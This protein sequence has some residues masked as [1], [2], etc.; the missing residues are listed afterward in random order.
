MKS[1]NQLMPLS[2][3]ILTAMSHQ[4]SAEKYDFALHGYIRSGILANSDGNRVDSVG[5]MP[6]GKWR[7]GNED[8]TKIEL[9]PQVTLTSDSG[10]VAKIQANITH[11]SKCTSDWNCLDED[12][13]AVQFREGYVEMTNLDFAPEVAFWGGKRYS[14]SN[15][16][17]HQFDWEYI[18]YNGTGGGFDNL[19]L[20]FARFDAGI[21]A[22]TPTDESKAFPVD[23]SDQGYPD[24]YSLN[25]WLKK[26]GGSPIDLEVVGHHMN[27][28]EKHVDAA[29]KGYGFTGIYNFDG[30]YGIAGGYS[31]F[32]VQYG[33][34]LAAGDSLGKNGWG[35]AN[36]EDTQSWRVVLDGM[37]SLGEWDISTFAYYQKDKNYRW[38]SSDEKGWGRTSWVAGVR[39]YQQI[40]KHFA[41]Q[42]EVGYEYLDDDNYKGVDG[43]GKGGLTKVTIAPTLTFDSGFWSRPQLR[44]FATYAK[45]D[46]GVS[47]ALDGNYNWDTNSI[48]AGGYS[49]SGKTD[50]LNF[51]IQAEVWF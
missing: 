6:D 45:W 34:G 3:L 32:V 35:W 16:S 27:N 41:M 30:F 48:S 10:A 12:G 15:T 9:V 19:D 49:R 18:Q 37:A 36:L 4:A 33:R 39:P 40:T 23:K 1:L 44:V 14:S 25:L 5:L 51:G 8:D 21:Y 47:D 26:I 29:E 28:S 42:Y 11:Q 38:W 2:L 50:T 31:K 22:F 43:K 20:G 24:D 7:L 17:S 13:K 46:K